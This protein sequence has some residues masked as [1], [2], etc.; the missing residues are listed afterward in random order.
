MAAV[1]LE[2]LILMKN[3]S[4]YGGIAPLAGVGA[5]SVKEDTR[6]NSA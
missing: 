3:I 1:A 5:F 4:Y 6:S 2:R